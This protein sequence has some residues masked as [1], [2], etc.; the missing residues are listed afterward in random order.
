MADHPKASRVAGGVD[1]HKDLRVAT[2]VDHRD[3]VLGVESLPATRHRYRLMLAWMR[4]FGDLQ[5]VSRRSF[6]GL[7]QNENDLRL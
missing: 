5:R 3:R 1:P 6:I 7:T 2:V 4:S